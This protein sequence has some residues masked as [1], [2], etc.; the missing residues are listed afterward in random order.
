MQEIECR[1]QAKERGCLSLKEAQPSNLTWKL[2]HR[3][4]ETERRL[5]DGMW[6]WWERRE[7]GRQREW[8]WEWRWVG[9][10]GRKGQA[11]EVGRYWQGVP[12]DDLFH[13]FCG[14]VAAPES[15]CGLPRV[16]GRLLP[17]CMPTAAHHLQIGMKQQQPWPGKPGCR[18]SVHQFLTN[19]SPACLH[20]ILIGPHML[21][22]RCLLGLVPFLESLIKLS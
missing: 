15:R 1:M 17:N 2:A 14:Q 19:Q 16:N 7:R 10:K 6:D 9:R 13:V 11:G 3:E 4:R 20:Q 5:G 18:I 8:E 21:A 12:F 22:T